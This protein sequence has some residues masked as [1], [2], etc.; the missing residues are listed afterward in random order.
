MAEV[1]ST[2][3]VEV[4]SSP[5]GIL[6][7]MT[8]LAPLKQVG[9]LVAIAAAIALGV[10]IALWSKEPPMRPLSS[11]PPEASMDVINYLEQQSIDYRVDST[12]RI[13][14]PQSRYKRIQIELGAQGIML[15]GTSDDPY[16][17]KDSGFG[18]SQRLE[19]ARLL[20]NQE[21]QLTNTL[22]QFNGVK[23]VK[24]HL[25]IPKESSFIKNRKKPSASVL[26]NLYSRGSLSDEQVDA[27]VDL[28]SGSIPN[29]ERSRVTITDQ[30]GRL[31]HSG[32]MSR[33]QRQSSKELDIVKERQEDIKS[34]IEQI[35]NP[36]I[37][38]GAYT[39]QVNVDM[40]FTQKE[41]TLQTFNP[42]LP[43]IRSERTIDDSRTD[44]TAAGIPGALSNQPPGA[45]VIPANAAGG[46]QDQ[47]ATA[48]G[49][50]R[51]EAERNY[52]LDTTISHILPQVGVVNRISVSVGL[53]YVD[54]P[55]NAGQ[56]ISRAQDQLSR[57]GR[58]IQAAIGFSV[59]RG[60]VVSVESFP[61]IAAETLPAPA[62]LPFYEEELF[63]TL[64]KPMIGLILGLV[65]IFAVLK[66]TLRRLSTVPA[67]TAGAAGV[68]ESDELDLSGIAGADGEMGGLADDQVVLAG[69]DNLELPPPTVG[70]V[71]KLEQAK[72]VVSNNPTLVAQLVK[73]WIEED[74]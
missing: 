61:F 69:H 68:G 42:D 10:F 74:S 65:L 52:D 31:Y 54:D 29:L 50:K 28:V 20:R 56:K 38:A 39:V 64:L 35:L 45:S 55:N 53:D 46:N 23:A 3:L 6:P 67:T 27:M 47:Q 37:G 4:D 19:Q 17:K 32:S 11:L 2:E 34:R 16:L 70:E 13:L 62:P 5:P 12:G 57:I 44:G 26:L 48:S 49:N 36:I 59:Q 72:G 71:K 25:A 60:D 58:L 41:Q 51:V 1:A 63:Q 66:P 8:S 33:S 43:A 15:E 22:N 30:F 14:I 21:L 40:D 7:G 73:S 9:I 18:V 24:V